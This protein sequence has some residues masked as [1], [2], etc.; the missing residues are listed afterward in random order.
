MYITFYLG[1]S[2]GLICVTCKVGHTWDKA[3]TAYQ[4]MSLDICLIVPLI[5]S[6]SPNAIPAA[7]FCR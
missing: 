1:T 7:I 5:R 3:Y 2:D 6:I 4:H